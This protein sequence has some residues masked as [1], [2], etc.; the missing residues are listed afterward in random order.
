MSGQMQA[1][2]KTIPDEIAGGVA[3]AVDRDRLLALEL[4]LIRIPSSAFEEHAIA[5]FLAGYL[6]DLGLDVEM[7]EVANPRKPGASSRQPVARLEGTGGG[8]SLMLNGHMDPGVEMLGW[9]V[10]PYAG[11]LD[12]DGWIW[13]IGAHDDKGGVAAMI[14]AVEAIVRTG[15]RLSGELLVCPVVAHKYGGVGTRALLDAG[16]RADRCINM[17]HSANTIANVCVGIVMARIRTRAPE[18]FFRFS[19]EARARY[20]N[21]VEQQME[22]LR[23]IGPSL[24]PV[25]PGGWLTFEPHADLP[26]FP[27]HTV[28]TI[29]KE[30]YYQPN[31]TG[32]S[33]RECE[34]IFQVRTVPG[35]TLASVR[36]DLLRLLEGIQAQHPA[37]DYE[38][39]IPAN[40]PRDTWF[41]DPCAL[42]ADD[43]IVEA[44]AAGHA[45]AA[46]EAPFI[47]GFGRLGN[48]GDG[49][50]LAAAGIPNVQYGPGDIRIYREWPTPDERVRLADLETAARA[51]AYAAC[52][53]CGEA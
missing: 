26:G 15:T 43:P 13:G 24:S 42:P 5:D 52:R 30:H 53:L 31:A 35:Q 21:P 8:P 50:I 33:S 22:V 32:L 23:R 40:G 46:G 27:M 25:L 14:S 51:V 17:E 47:G 48:V 44:L 1:V 37:F 18:L 41:Q 10:D 39:E 19:D 45:L 20:M 7:M 16:I 12:D 29:H 3:R 38:L 4:A 36:A 34:M 11:I 9:S 6:D 28:D 49:N 2:M